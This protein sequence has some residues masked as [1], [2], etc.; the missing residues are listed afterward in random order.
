M[1]GIY[2]RSLRSVFAV[3]LLP[4]KKDKESEPS[5]TSWDLFCLTNQVIPSS[6][7]LA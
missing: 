6:D 1:I 4:E 5:Q 3:E 2:D 7:D